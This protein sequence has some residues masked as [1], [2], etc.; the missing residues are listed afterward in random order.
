MGEGRSGNNITKMFGGL[1]A[2]KHLTTLRN[3]ALSLLPL[4]G[5]AIS[6]N[7][8]SMEVLSFLCRNWGCKSQNISTFLDFN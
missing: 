1:M 2:Y 7:L 4:Q 3:L 6:S 8:I 5:L